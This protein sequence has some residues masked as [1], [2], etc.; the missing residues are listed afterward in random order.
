MP[1]WLRRRLPQLHVEGHP[2][3]HLPATR[4]VEPSDGELDGLEPVNAS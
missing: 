1:A 3:E 2:E 4:P